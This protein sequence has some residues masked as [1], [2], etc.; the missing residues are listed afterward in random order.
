VAVACGVLAALAALTRPDGLIYVAAYPLAVLTLLRWREWVRSLV[1]M[2]VSVVGFL[3]PYGAYLLW[4]VTTF[5]ALLPNTAVA[6]AQGLPSL[7][8]L[9]RPSVLVD[10]VGWWSVL[11]AGVLVVAALCVRSPASSRSVFAVLLVPLVLAVA[12]FAVLEPDWM[13]LFRFA[14][15]VWP[16]GTVAAVVAAAR[17]LPRLGRVPLTAAVAVATVAV[18]AAVTVWVPIT[19]TFR[20]G[21]TVPMCVVAQNTGLSFDGYAAQLGLR[22][23]TL[24]APDIGGAALTS[25][26]RIV[27]LAGL[28]DK[29]VARFWAADDMAGLRTY[30]F[31]VVRPDFITSHSGWS[32]HTG[33]TA[34]PRLAAGYVLVSAPSTTPSNDE[35]VRRD[36]VARPGQLAELRAFART[37]VKPADDR[38]R[39]QPRGSCGDTLRV[40]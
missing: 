1:A 20:A 25:R 18:V 12:A 30:L 10:H 34:D 9:T 15:P 35:W 11:L 3:L 37:V 40:R 17:V 6:K 14:T 29:Q 7:A 2:V 16:L 33:L 19:R 26:L 21:P 32:R 8:D 13:P 31:E 36:L 38:A 39:S 27:D 5:G 28:A 23:G 22:T 24:V 4:R